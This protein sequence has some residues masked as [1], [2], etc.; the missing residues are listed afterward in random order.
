M[1]N[2][3]NKS[4][5]S[6]KI[7]DNSDNN[8]VLNSKNILFNEGEKKPS[9]KRKIYFYKRNKKNLKNNSLEELT[10]KFITY[11]LE[12]NENNIINL[13]TVMKKTKIKKSKLKIITEVF[14]GK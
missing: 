1:K 4:N 5:Y 3:N 7:I 11:I 9:M 12:N 14:E 8:Y 2:K 13:N 10:K 6:S